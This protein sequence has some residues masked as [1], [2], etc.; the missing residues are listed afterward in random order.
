MVILPHLNTIA[1]FENNCHYIS[2]EYMNNRICYMFVTYRITQ[3]LKI[4]FVLA[5]ASAEDWITSILVLAD[6]V[7]TA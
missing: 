5:V 1:V 4:T 6:Q 7:S 2:V 3:A